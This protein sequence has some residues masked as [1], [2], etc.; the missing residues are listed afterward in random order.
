[1]SNVA[2]I[3]SVL[4]MDVFMAG[5]SVTKAKMPSFISRGVVFFV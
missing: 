5:K 3:L 4:S 2:P 1:L